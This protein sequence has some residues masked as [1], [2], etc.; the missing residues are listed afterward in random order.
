MAEIIDHVETRTSYVQADGKTY[1]RTEVVGPNVDNQN[2]LVVISRAD[3]EV[4]PDDL[5]AEL[6]AARVAAVAEK[7]R[8]DQASTAEQAEIDRLDDLASDLG[9]TIG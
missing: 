1:L 3:T 9:L 8:L 2:M 7:D 6:A 5:A 4:D